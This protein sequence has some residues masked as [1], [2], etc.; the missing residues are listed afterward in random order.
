MKILIL[1]GTAEA[2]DLAGRLVALGHD[3]TSA[4]A[5]RTQNPVLPNGAVRMGGFGG[6]AGLAAYLSSEGIER[7]VDATHPYAGIISANAVAAAKAAG[8]PLVRYM[9]PGWDQ[10]EGADWIKV[11]TATQAAAAL[12]MGAEVLLTT[13]HAGLADFLGRSDC[14]FLVRLIEAPALDIP[15]HARLLQDRPPYGLAD[16][17]A[18]L[19]RERITHL[20]TKNS[21]GGQTSAK[22][23]AAQQTGVTVIMIERPAYGAALEVSSVDATI[24]AFALRG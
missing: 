22:L 9:R 14:R 19:T 13:G 24:G 18:L 4:L 6:A 15:S 17:M 2:R 20:V 16:E 10:P 3:V 1:G 7:L 11:A 12:P 21:G 5:G 23:E 8:V